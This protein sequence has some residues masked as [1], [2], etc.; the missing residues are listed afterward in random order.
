MACKSNGWPPA[1][2][3]KPERSPAESTDPGPSDNI[4]WRAYAS[5]AKKTCW[6]RR[7]NY[8][9]VTGGV[10]YDVMNSA[11]DIRA[12]SHRIRRPEHIPLTFP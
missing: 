7:S 8:E 3:S 9:A 11:V 12:L 6:T 4:P 2:T 10:R 5:R 1:S